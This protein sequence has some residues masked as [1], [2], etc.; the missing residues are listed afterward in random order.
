MNICTW[1]HAVSQQSYLHELRDNPHSST[2]THQHIKPDRHD[3][4]NSADTK[5]SAAKKVRMRNSRVTGKQ[6]GRVA[7]VSNQDWAETSNCAQSCLLLPSI[8]RLE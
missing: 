2:R 3:D 8:V 1:F 4:A 5:P 7:L 6:M